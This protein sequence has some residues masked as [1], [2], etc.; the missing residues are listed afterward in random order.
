MG[1]DGLK[2]GEVGFGSKLLGLNM[3]GSQPMGI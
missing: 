2:N 3:V 1:C